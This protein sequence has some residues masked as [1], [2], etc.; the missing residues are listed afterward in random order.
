MSTR[1]KLGPR[2]PKSSYAI[3]DLVDGKEGALADVV[4]LTTER[5]FVIYLIMRYVPHGVFVSSPMRL[6][7]Y[8]STGM[9][10]WITTDYY[11]AARGGP[12]LVVYSGQ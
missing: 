11:V 9:T 5:A 1:Q 4:R 10:A 7:L 2:E 3:A 12:G 6:A 8:V